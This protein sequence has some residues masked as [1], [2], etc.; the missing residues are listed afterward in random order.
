MH[1]IQ[2]NL[3]DNIDNFDFGAMSL[4]DI[5]SSIGVSHPQK[6]KHHLNQLEKKGF[7]SIDKGNGIIKRSKPNSTQGSFFSIP[8]VGSANCGPAKLLTDDNIQSY[9]KIS[10]DLI[11]NQEDHF[12]VRAKGDSMNQA[13]INGS[14]IESGDLVVINKRFTSPTHGDYVLAVVDEAATL[15]RFYNKQGKVAL[16]PESSAQY[17]P[18]VLSQE[19]IEAV[20]FN[21]KIVDVIKEFEF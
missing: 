6:V 21:G 10:K 20:V 2:K 14:N 16:V 11:K 12:I 8:V 19:S 9:V 3:L 17:P 13:S 5:A 15:K 7:I 18:I 4:R 1:D